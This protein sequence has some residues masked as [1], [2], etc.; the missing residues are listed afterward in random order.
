MTLNKRNIFLLSIFVFVLN[1]LFA[2]EKNVQFGLATYYSD[3]FQGRRTTSGERYNN[4]LY[5]AA[6]ATLPLFSLVKVT[7]LKNNES[8]IVKVNDRCVRSYSRIIDLSKAAAKKI[9]LMLSG[10][11]KVKLEVITPSDLNIIDNAPD[12][13]I[14][15][16]QFDVNSLKN[17]LF[18]RTKMTDNDKQVLLN[19]IYSKI[20]SVHFW[21]N[22]LGKTDWLALNYFYYSVLVNDVC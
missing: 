17:K 12:S 3:A 5:T 13:V 11:A 6:H 16:I 2:Q 4:I 19:Y 21:K 22:W 7:N 18:N 8:V 15:K 1:N 14:K 9:D 20:P 10:I